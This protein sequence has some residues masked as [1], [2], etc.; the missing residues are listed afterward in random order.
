MRAENEAHSRM[1]S[2]CQFLFVEWNTYNY[3]G[4]VFPEIGKLALFSSNIPFRY[5]FSFI[6]YPSTFEYDVNVR[7]RPI[8][9]VFVLVYSV[10]YCTYAFLFANESLPSI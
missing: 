2:Q 6:S 1:S 5:P 10:L 4:H 8:Y 7:V 3:I 9:T